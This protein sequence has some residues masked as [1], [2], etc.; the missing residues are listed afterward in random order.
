MDSR[1]KMGYTNIMLKRAFNLAKKERYQ[2]AEAV[3]QKIL[4]KNPTWMAWATLGIILDKTQRHQEAM[5][6]F[7]KADKLSKNQPEIIKNMG[8][9]ALNLHQYSL[10]RE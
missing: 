9:C 5:E 2:E 7:Q 10:D 4:A 3:L 1:S 8:F 6:A